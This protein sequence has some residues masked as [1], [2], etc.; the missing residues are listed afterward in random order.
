MLSAALRKNPVILVPG[1]AGSKL[2]DVCPV[3]PPTNADKG[4]QFRKHK[5]DFVNLNIFDKQ[6]KEKFALKYDKA[7][8]R[9]SVDDTID[10]H[11]FGGVE[12][13]RNLCY[14]CTRIDSVFNYFFKTDVINKMYN[15]RYFDTLIERLESSGYVPT[16]DLFGAP[17][18]FRKIMVRTYLESYFDRLKGLIERSHDVNDRPAVVVAHSIGCLIIYIFLVEYCDPVWK[19]KHIDKFVSVGGPYGGSSIALKTLL[20]GLPKL[21]LLKEQYHEV[22]RNST[23]LL[24]ALPN[25]LG[26]ERGQGLVHDLVMS[27]TYNRRNYA[28]LLPEPSATLWKNDVLPFVPTLIQNTGVKTVIVTTTDCKTEVA[29]AYEGM[30]PKFMT[31]PVTVFYASGDGVI[32]SNSLKFHSVRRKMYPNY[33]FAQVPDNEH[34]RLLYSEKL[35]ELIMNSS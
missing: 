23:G 24:L 16:I 6:W 17:Y 14:D 22:M 1:F 19:R 15:Y 18:D 7:A 12:C 8:A 25:E 4:L 28:E 32:P 27:K 13:I 20:S 29:Y 9:L 11:S 2:V 30:D 21:N 34:T 5:N 10:V 3:V 31:E 33:T 26:Y 35:F